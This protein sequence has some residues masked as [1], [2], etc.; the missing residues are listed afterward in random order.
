ME[1][2]EK[3][4]GD[5]IAK[6]N[7]VTIKQLGLRFDKVAVELLRNLRTFVEEED[8]GGE[9]VLVLITAPIKMPGKSELEI[10][11]KIR[12][13]LNVKVYSQDRAITVA[14]NEVWIRILKC[15][16]GPHRKFV[17]LVYN[18]NSGVTML[19]DLATKWLLKGKMHELP[20][21]DV[22]PLQKP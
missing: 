22:S 13:F 3:E 15:P 14:G 5:E 2:I 8:L 20:R 9:T 21:R 7:G 12:D 18:R 17:G 11:K 6:S 10:G 4:I 1:N 16:S 19:L